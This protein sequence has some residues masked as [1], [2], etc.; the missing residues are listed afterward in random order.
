MR[1]SALS[2]VCVVI[3][4]LVLGSCVAHGGGGCG[5]CHAAPTPSHTD[6]QPPAETSRVT[7][8]CPMHSDVTASA[9]GACPKCGMALVPK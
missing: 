3:V 8:T 2:I 9:P 7:Y 5:S 6:P 1:N 4:V